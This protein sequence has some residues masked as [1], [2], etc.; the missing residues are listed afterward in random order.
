MRLA[1]RVEE[2]ESRVPDAI[3]VWERIILG[4]EVATPEEQ[5]RIEA[6]RALGH[7]L[8]IRRI[9]PSRTGGHHEA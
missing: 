6:A 3:P 5:E 9:I 7:S 8:I 4:G 1:N 2:L